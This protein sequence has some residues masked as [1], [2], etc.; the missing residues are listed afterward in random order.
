[1]LAVCLHSAHV[2]FEAQRLGL[3]N[4]NDFIYYVPTG[5]Y[6]ERSPAAGG[7][8]DYSCPARARGLRAGFPAGNPYAIGAL[9]LADGGGGAFAECAH[10]VTNIFNSRL[11]QLSHVGI[12]DHLLEPGDAGHSSGAAGVPAEG[13]RIDCVVCVS[14]H[15]EHHLTRGGVCARAGGAEYWQGAGPRSRGLLAV[16]RQSAL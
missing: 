7:A 9:V 15:G 5:G 16:D 2:A 12:V 1:M 4:D 6:L 11:G 8:R 3:R 10:P 14:S 13:A